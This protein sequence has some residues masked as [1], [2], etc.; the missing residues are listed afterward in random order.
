LFIDEGPVVQVRSSTGKVSI[1][2]D[3]EPGKAYSGPL[4]VLVDRISASA[5]EIFAAAIQDYGRGIII[6]SQTFGKGTV[7]NAVGLNRFFPNTDKKLGQLK[8]TIAKFYRI[9]GGSTQHVGVIP[10]ISFPSRFELMDFG[11]SAQKNA[12]LWDQIGSLNYLQNN[13]LTTVIPKL[14]TRTNL[15]VSEDPRFVE[16]NQSLEEFDRN[17]NRKQISLNIEV[18]EKEREEA[19]KKKK[20][21]KEK[22]KDNE[23]LLITESARILSDYIMISEK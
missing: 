5:S 18:R 20:E 22:E 19:E 17:R 2:W 6:G 14:T 15:R 11:E 12:L 13:D 9:D 16:L 3:D 23:D 21:K 10:D 1:E 8:I 7:Q 4:A